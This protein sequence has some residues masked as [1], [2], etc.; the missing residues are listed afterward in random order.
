MEAFLTLFLAVIVSML[1]TIATQ[2]IVEMTKGF[3]E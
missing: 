1:D 3:D 2:Q